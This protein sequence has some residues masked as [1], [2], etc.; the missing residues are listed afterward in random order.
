MN[1]SK[2]TTE[3]F[4]IKAREIHGNRY[5]YSETIYTMSKNKINIICNN[6]GVFTQRAASHL[7][8]QGCV[9]CSAERRSILNKSD[10]NKVIM[11]F[12]K[13]HNNKYDY[14]LVVYKNNY[15]KIKII[16]PNHGVFEQVPEKHIRGSGCKKCHLD[17]QTYTNIEFI[18]RCIQKHGFKY[19]YSLVKYVNC[20]TQVKIICPIHGEFEQTPYNHL[21]GECFSCSRKNI[22]N[23]KRLDGKDFIERASKI[24]NN[25]YDY[26]FVKYINVDTL[27]KII[28]PNHGEFK[29][30]PDKHL[31]ANQG[32]PRCKSS[33]GENEIIIFF[34]NNNIQYKHQKKFNNCKYKNILPFDFYLPKYNLCIEYDG[35]QHYESIKHFGGNEEF[36]K[37][38]IKDKIKTKYCKKNGIKLIR[39]KYNEN[40]EEKL[41]SLFLQT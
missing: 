11:T 9:R 34:E 25:K 13:I 1:N 22:G 31:Y 15:T 19:D 5:D 24:H 37:R 16:C 7:K 41:N 21:K 12:N 32:C 27:I 3:I 36:E 17:K 14:S 6:H 38:K 10:L 28:C 20:D 29:Q 26:S 40:I 30:T 18:E 39:I 2:L 35:K 8:G 33:K 4:I 23:K